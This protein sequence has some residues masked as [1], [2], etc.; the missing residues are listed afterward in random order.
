MGKLEEALSR[1]FSDEA[2]SL[3]SVLL[4]AAE[5]GTVSYEE[6]EVREG[7]R[8]EL[9]EDLL[10]L[11]E[12]ERILLPV[13][14]SKGLAWEDRILTLR[15]GERYEMPLVVRY[16][17]LN[18]YETGEWNPG[19]SVEKCLED[20][21]ESEASEVLKLY[22]RIREKAE[23]RRITAELLKKCSGELGLDLKIGKVIA[24]LKGAGVISPCFRGS[25]YSTELQYEINPSLF[26]R[27]SDIGEEKS[28]LSR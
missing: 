19:Y 14:T 22:N 15:N 16:L 5:R 11:M 7:S 9:K 27:S 23:T 6:V 10:L 12:A 8:R 18:A 2:S 28:V 13:R 21:G 3:A 26:V 1:R 4:L 17:I 20:M 24:E 25:M